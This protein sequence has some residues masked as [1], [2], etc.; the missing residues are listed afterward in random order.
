MLMV[1]YTVLT[2]ACASK[3]PR[4]DLER[5]REGMDKA[6]VL[7]AA[8]SPKR[9]YHQRGQD[10]W[11]YVFF[12]G[13]RELYQQIDFRDGIVTKVNAVTGKA[14]FTGRLEGAES[15]EDFEKT[16]KAHSQESSG[17]K[18]VPDDGKL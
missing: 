2:A 15:M 12:E 3:T 4:V 1:L 5:V 6:R 8:G 16:V 9:T 7:D 13:D 11:V 10:H 14:N 18:D 17:F